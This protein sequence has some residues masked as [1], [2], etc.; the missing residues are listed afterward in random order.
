MFMILFSV[1]G[2]EIDL[3][4]LVIGFTEVRH[5]SFA[6][7]SNNDRTFFSYFTDHV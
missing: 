3:T 2:L 5:V 7:N 6:N 4:S 1:V